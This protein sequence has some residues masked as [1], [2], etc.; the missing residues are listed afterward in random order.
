M[1][2]SFKLEAFEGP[3]DLLL[4]L[5]EKNKVDIY[6]IPIS[7][8]TDQYLEYL[9]EMDKQDAEVTSEFLVMAA[10]LLEIKAKM[11]IPKPQEAEEDEEDPRAELVEQLLEYKMYKYMSYELKDKAIT[12]SKAL[13]KTPTIPDEVREYEPPIDLDK[14]IGNVTIAKLK[15]IFDDVMQRSTEKVNTQAMKYGRVRREPLNIPEKI[16]EIRS[17]I[18]SGSAFSFRQLI[19]KQPTKLNVIATFLAVL[20]LM[21]TGEL[22]AEQ[23]ENMDDIRL[24]AGSQEVTTVGFNENES[25]N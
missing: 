7:L 12:A 16:T 5:I 3:L 21:K 23:D 8:I 19:E 24:S 13:Y 15:A 25:Y 6:D 2:I 22:V 9:S 11:L 17:F 18:S 1:E 14:F 4:H 20:E 10:T